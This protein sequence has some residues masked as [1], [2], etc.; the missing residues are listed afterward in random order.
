MLP[1]TVVL[2][3]VCGHAGE[4]G[5]GPGGRPRASCLKCASLERHR[6]LVGVLPAFAEAAGHGPL[7]DV[8]PSPLTSQRIEAVADAAGVPYI[9]LDFDPAADGRTVTVQASLTGLPL[10]DASVGLMICFH[11]LEHVPDDA[12]AMA[13]IARVLSPGGVAVVQVPHRPDSPTDED[14][15]APVEERVRR[16]GQAD[17]VRY[18]GAD[19]EERLTRAGLT[20]RAL[21]MADL[22]TELETDLL[23]ISRAEPLWLCTV[24][25]EADLAPLIEQCRDS[26]RA[27]VMSALER[28]IEER[29]DLAAERTRLERKRSSLQKQ[30]TAVQNRRALRLVDGVASKVRGLKR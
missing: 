4:L 11:V 15:S 9:A 12:T 13:E 17:H 24:G 3:P 25:A 5:N 19:F 28:V 21:T 14:P 2:C 20:V 18:Y 8:A 6:A 16:F 26:A 30:L 10:A 29:D 23:G 22:Y 7:I 1:T 27:A